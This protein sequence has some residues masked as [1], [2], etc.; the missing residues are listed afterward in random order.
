MAKSITVKNITIGEGLPCICVPL[1]GSNLAELWEEA[2][3]A[4]ALHPD[5]VE[6]R[7]DFFQKLFQPEEVK[8]TLKELCGILEEIPIIFTVRT[9]KEGGNLP[10]SPEDY[11]H[12]LKDTA[13]T[14]LPSLIDVEVFQLA[15]DQQQELISAIHQMG[16]LIVGSNHH[17]ESTP[18]NREMEE[19]FRKEDEA[20][21]DILKLAVMPKD[22]GDVARLLQVTGERSRSGQS[23]PVIT[24]SM[25]EM[26]SASRFCGEIFGSAVTF[27]TVKSASAPGQL[28][29]GELRQM[30]S[31]FHRF[32]KK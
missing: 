14:G 13:A 27:A 22:Y 6:W 3:A 32:A 18:S 29:V 12:I 28:P 30:L 8:R 10:V 5:L 26:G 11:I 9:S 15:P 17:F 25:G 24:M 16:I 4:A 21:A 7:A 20:G 2:K 31:L 23:K 1:T 19:I